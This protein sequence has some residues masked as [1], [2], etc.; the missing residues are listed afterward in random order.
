MDC[1]SLVMMSPDEKGSNVCPQWNLGSARRGLRVYPLPYKHFQ[2]IILPKRNI[3]IAKMF[4]QEIFFWHN[5]FVYPKN[6]FKRAVFFNWHPTPHI[7]P[8]HVWMY[9]PFSLSFVA[10][11]KSFELH[12]S[13][14]TL[15]QS[16]PFFC[17]NRRRTRV[18]NLGR[19]VWDF[20]S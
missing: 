4:S 2:D 6:S 18:Q 11:K 19:R 3:L 12:D 20:F 17:Y 14:L 10:S 5:I 16:Q 1:R 13:T 7:T 9:S 8:G 15:C